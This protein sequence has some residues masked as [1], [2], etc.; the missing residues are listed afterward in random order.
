MPVTT[1]KENAGRLRS[2]KNMSKDHDEMRRRR[3]DVTVELRKVKRDEQMLK[4]RNMT[5]EPDTPLTESNKQI[6]LDLSIPSIVENVRS[7]NVQKQLSGVQSC[8]RL[9]SKEV[10]PPLDSVI[11]SGVV[12]RLVELLGCSGNH[13]LQFEAAW[14]LTNIASG[15]SQHTRAVV[16]AGAVQ[17]FV[18]LLSSE[19]LNVVD[20]A[21]WALGNIAGDGPECRDFTVQ[22]GI[23]QP[24]LALIKP[25][26]KMGY[27]RNITWTISN[28][29]RNKVPH[30]SM[31]SVQQVLPALA[32]LL[33]HSDQEVVSDTCWALSYLTDG[34][35]E[36]IQAVLDAGVV[37]MLIKMLNSDKMTCITPALRAI[38]NIVTGNDIQTQTVLD[39]K[40]LDH[41]QRLLTHPKSNI[42]KEAA[43][44]ISNI[45]AGQPSQIQA[46]VDAGLVPLLVN[47]LSKGEFRAQKEAVWAITNLTAG[48]NVQQVVAAVQAGVLKPLCDLLVVK[49]TKVV[50]VILD[51]LANILQAAEKLQHLEQVCM[52]IEECEGLD[53][54]EA[55]QQHQNSMVYQMALSIIDKYFS[56]E[57]DDQALAPNTSGGEYKFSPAALAI[58]E[59]GYSF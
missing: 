46:I 3:N 24:L 29:C 47:I 13:G 11:E 7:P 51:A 32:Y 28:L 31:E 36:R 6:P 37:P 17:V 26:M 10:N 33:S 52:M 22:C 27:L 16:Q 1:A 15:K 30:P 39:H 20:Q 5:I 50:T 41:F 45:T 44:T 18:A 54:I 56:E 19:H 14:A 49:E 35:T 8:R 38:G 34:S 59:G 43:W 58:P 42:Q 12:P 25:D 9:L 48:G 2:F 57:E 55:L 4:R 40:A 21:V 53:K 23:I